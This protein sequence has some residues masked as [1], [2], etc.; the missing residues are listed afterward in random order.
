M[1]RDISE[2]FNLD[3]FMAEFSL[4]N[5]LVDI[6]TFITDNNILSFYKIHF[7]LKLM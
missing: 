7:I 4:P 1:S 6:T 5:I 3:Q 2:D